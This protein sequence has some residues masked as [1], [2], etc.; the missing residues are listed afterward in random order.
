MVNLNQPIIANNRNLRKK[1]SYYHIYI[2]IKK[3]KKQN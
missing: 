2:L 1:E 3:N